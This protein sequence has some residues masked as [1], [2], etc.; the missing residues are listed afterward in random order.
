MRALVIR[1]VFFLAHSGFLRDINL[2]F[3]EFSSRRD[4]KNAG[5][6]QKEGPQ[7]VGN[8][9]CTVTHW[10]IV[11]SNIDFRI[12]RACATPAK[13]QTQTASYSSGKS[14]REHDRHIRGQAARNI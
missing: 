3:P 11:S 14:F 2:D 4:A 1:D 5:A 8:S 12:P 9:F 10:T 6:W 7:N 13:V